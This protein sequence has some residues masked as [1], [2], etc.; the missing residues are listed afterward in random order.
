MDNKQIQELK[1]ELKSL[2]KKYDVM[3]GFTCSDSSDTYG[4]YG[5]GIVI[6]ERKTG[7]ILF[8]EDKWAISEIDL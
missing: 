8:K 2:L 7:N 6:Q 1:K 5:E 4:I 3:I